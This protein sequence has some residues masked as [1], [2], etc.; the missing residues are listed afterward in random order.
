MI[1][2]ATGDI[3]LPKGYEDFLKAVDTMKAEPDLFLIAGDIVH[4]GDVNE[5]DKFYN[6]IFGKFECPVVVCFGNTEL[7]KFRE[8]VKAIYK[9]IRFLDDEAW[10]V[11]V[12]GTDVGIFGTTGSLEKATQWQTANIPN[13]QNL[14]KSR[15]KLAEHGLRKMNTKL[16]I[17][18]MHYA[19]TFKTLDGE[20]PNYFS[21]LGSREYENVIATQKPSMVIH[22]HSHN[23]INKAVVEGVPVFNAAFPVNKEILMIDTQAQKQGLSKFTK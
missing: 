7:P 19:P 17:L 3:H 5:F 12:G 8:E 15:V 9:D 11:N 1:I 22:G 18:L 23:G 16:K 14:Y 4:H 2:A 20:N 6:I 10:S 21:T 13:I